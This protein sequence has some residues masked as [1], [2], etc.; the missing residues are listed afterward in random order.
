[1]NTPR[2]PAPSWATMEQTLRDWHEQSLN[3]H[4][5]IW[6]SPNLEDM[7]D[8]I[9]KAMFC[10]DTP[11]DMTPDNRWMTQQEGAAA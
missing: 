11:R 3:D 8:S 6:L 2:K 9:S 4:E 7:A 5:Y 10:A 1:M